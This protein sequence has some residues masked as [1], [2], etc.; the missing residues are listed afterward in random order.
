MCYRTKLNAV[1]KDI[2]STFNASFIEPESY[3]PMD[4][5]NGFSFTKTPVITD[6]NMGEIEMYNWG[7]IPFWAK[8]DKIRKKTLNARIETVKDKPAYRNSAN[9]RC[10]IIANGYYEWQWLDPKGKE[11]KKYLIT[12]KDQEIFAFAGI[13]SSWKNPQNHELV[14]SYSILTTD[15]NE[16]MSEIHNSKKRMPVVLKK[17]DRENWLSGAEV[18]NFAFPY[19]VELEAKII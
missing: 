1:L 8:D 2:E 9:N 6:E 7:L 13:Y 14:N 15:A 19:T 11:K 10:L 4:E 3:T 12:P 18:L 17:E 5:I 16:L